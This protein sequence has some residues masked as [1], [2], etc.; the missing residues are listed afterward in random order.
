MASLEGTV[1]AAATETGF[2]G[3]ICIDAP[4]GG[5]FARAYGFAD[6]AHRIANTPETRIAIASG[7]KGFT[8]LA[9]VS[10]IEDGV[11]AL[12]TTARSVL[13]GDLPLIADNVTVEH[14]LSHRSGIGDYLDESELEVTDHAMPVPVHQLD[15]TEAFLSVL[16]GHPT[17]F[18]SGERFEYNNGAFVVLALIAERLSGT[19]YHDLV[20]ERVCAPAE[21][22]DT[23]FLRMDELPGD[24]ALGYLFD[25]GLRT[26]VLHMP[27]LATGDG[28][29]FTTAADVRAFWTALFAGR[30]VSERWLRE[31][32]R[33]RGT[34]PDD[35]RRYGLGLWLHPTGDVVILNGFDAG[36]SFWTAHDPTTG[37]TRTVMSNTTEGAWPIVEV[38][39]GDDGW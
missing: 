18:P 12:G 3:V 25:E 14:L 37:E 22:R 36:A 29:I 23:D 28:G 33:P 39:S 4:D 9:V 35:S 21:M 2:S 26:N 34:D 5:S 13:G 31:M 32:L 11:L 24:A 38:L 30:I 27:V 20:R 1:D 6:R 16:D 15:T 10:L 19:P 7:S 8:A 17:A